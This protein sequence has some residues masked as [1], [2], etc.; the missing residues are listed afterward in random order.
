MLISEKWS[1]P[2]ACKRY[3]FDISVMISVW[4]TVDDIKPI[5]VLWY[6]AH[7]GL[8]YS[9]CRSDVVKVI[10]FDRYQKHIILILVTDISYLTSGRYQPTRHPPISVWWHHYDITNLILADIR[11]L[12]SFRYHKLISVDIGRYPRYRG[13]QSFSNIRKIKRRGDRGKMGIRGE[14]NGLF[15]SL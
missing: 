7:I 8:M 15:F 9:R 3:L 13:A 5:S 14:I 10:S 6:G 11:Y 12:P 1:R 2:M 4:Y